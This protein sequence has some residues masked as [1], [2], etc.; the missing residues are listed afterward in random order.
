M[1]T[2]AGSTLLASLFDA[3]GGLIAQDDNAFG[4]LEI[5]QYR[6]HVAFERYES[7]GQRVPGPSTRFPGIH[8]GYAQLQ[9]APIPEPGTAGL[10]ALGLALLKS[11]RERAR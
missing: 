7:P 6:L 3:D 10:L 11:R 4:I 2:P 9:L 5:G 8:G 1:T